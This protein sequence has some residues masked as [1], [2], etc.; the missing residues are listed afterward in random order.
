[1]LKKTMLASAL[2]AALMLP[3]LADKRNDT[4]AATQENAKA[5]LG[6]ALFFDPGL[7]SPAGQ[8]CATCHATDA[9]FTDPGRSLPVSKGVLHDRVGNRNTPTA[10][11]AAF[12]P[13]FHFDAKEGLYVGGQ[14]LDGRAATLEKQAEEP[15]LNPLEMA[16]P[17]KR[18]VVGKVRRAAYG[19]DFDKV[20]GKGALD[21]TDAAYERIAA[22]LAAFQRTPRFSPFSSKYDAYLAGKVRLS[23]QEMRGLRLFEA[24]DK[25]NCAACHASRPGPNGEAPLFTDFTYD[26]L[27]VPRNPDNPFYSLPAQLNPA[28][29]QW[30][31]RGLGAV[32]DKRAED[33][34]FKVPTLR[35][36][37]LTA[38]YMHN[39]YFK[40]LRGTVVF[41]N[42][43]D[44]KPLCRKNR[45]TEEAALKQQCWP[46][47]EVITNVNQDELGDLGLTEREI[48]DIVA[49]MKTLTD[50]WTTKP[51]SPG[52]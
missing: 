48:D 17:D 22:A 23:K 10:M 32:V 3:A 19:A 38:P 41:Y 39:G 40:T 50:G 14:F 5:E 34:K 7:S 37:E 9:A 52:S 51:D 42:D 1:M 26:N 24:E 4:Q 16:N 45:V 11:Y 36:V 25:G 29:S 28:G 43:R 13:A 44:R 18:S 47:P 20:F 33:G 15:F 12:S 49:F 6:Q 8:S 21:D 30:V 46:A 27:G 2:A 35:N 31:D